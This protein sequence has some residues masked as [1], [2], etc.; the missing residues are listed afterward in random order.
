[1]E[2]LLSGKPVLEKLTVIV[3]GDIMSEAFREKFEQYKHAAENGMIKF[4]LRPYIRSPPDGKVWLSGGYF[5]FA[6]NL[7]YFLINF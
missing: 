3:Y 4:V 6:K 1:M 2:H 5:S 7:I